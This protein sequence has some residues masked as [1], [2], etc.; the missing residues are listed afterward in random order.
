MDVPLHILEQGCGRS[1]SAK[2][3]IE[4]FAG[5]REAFQASRF[6]K[7]NGRSIRKL[8]IAEIVISPFLI[9]LL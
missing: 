8:F 4:K 6:L 7:K 2:V 9:I 3:L 1:C 5:L